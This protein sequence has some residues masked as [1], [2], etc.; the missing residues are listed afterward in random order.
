MHKIHYI[1]NIKFVLCQNLRNINIFSDDINFKNIIE[2]IIRSTPPVKRYMIVHPSGKVEHVDDIEKITRI[3]PNYM[4]IKSQDVLKYANS[5]TAIPGLQVPQPKVTLPLDNDQLI[6]TINQNQYA[7]VEQQINKMLLS[8]NLNTQISAKDMETEELIVP[9]TAYM[10]A[11][12]I[13][14]AVDIASKQAINL[15]NN[16]SQQKVNNLLSKEINQN[17]I[18]VLP[19]VAQPSS[20]FKSELIITH[21]LPIIKAQEIPNIQR[22]SENST[23]IFSTQNQQPI[24]LDVA[25]TAESNKNGTGGIFTTPLRHTTVST[26]IEKSDEI[27]NQTKVESANFIISE[28]ATAQ[29]QHEVGICTSE[30]SIEESSEESREYDSSSF[31]VSD[32]VQVN[33]DN[34]NNIE[35]LNQ[36]DNNIEFSTI[37]TNNLPFFYINHE[38]SQYINNNES[39]TNVTVATAP[40]ISSLNKTEVPIDEQLNTNTS[41]TR[42]GISSE[43]ENI[44]RKYA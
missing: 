23:D 40:L 26:T 36:P 1:E 9:S 20:G 28:N 27:K 11:S 25:L 16:N 4:M 33:G 24:S 22:A 15:P 5:K 44:T 39:T 32:I 30:E 18:S 42:R 13:P 34:F 2:D 7:T 29:L 41:S 10:V 3:H 43:S 8:Q 12:K 35:P 17:I 19:S 31:P 38:T 21:S 37:E 14:F 6:S